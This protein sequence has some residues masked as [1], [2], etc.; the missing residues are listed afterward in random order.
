[1]NRIA[2]VVDPDPVNSALGSDPSF[3]E[4]YKDLR[5][6]DKTVGLPAVSLR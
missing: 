6:S 2:V 1:M 4:I 3:E 5:R